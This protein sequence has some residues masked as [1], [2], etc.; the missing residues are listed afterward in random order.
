[1]RVRG[2]TRGQGLNQQQ[3]EGKDS[4]LGSQIIEA[5]WALNTCLGAIESELVTSWE[6][7]SE[8]AWLLH[9]SLI[10]NMHQIEMTLAVWWEQS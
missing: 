5:L 2:Q 7:M 10:Y 1:M 9:W 3:E 4:Q 6:A 8:S